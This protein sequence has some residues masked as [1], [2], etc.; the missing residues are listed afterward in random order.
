MRY[1]IYVAAA[2]LSACAAAPAPQS[3]V[4]T[5]DS[6]S[7][8]GARYP[9][10]LAQRATTDASIYLGNLDAKIEVLEGE[11]ARKPTANTGATLAGALLTRFRIV[12]RLDDGERAL[13]LSSAAAL[14]AADQP[15]VHRV[16]ASALSAF[17]LFTDAE[18]ALMQAQAAGASAQSLAAV[19][20]DLQMAQGHYDALHADFEHSA[21]PVA[22]FYEL[23][24]R[25]DLRL[26][27]GD[28]DGATRWYRTAQDFYS[29]VDPLPLAWLYTQQ[30][31]ALL[32]AG[33]TQQAKRFFESAHMRLPQYYLAT[34]HLAECE[35][36]LGNVQHARELYQGVITQTGNPEFLAALALLEEMDGHADAAAS[37]RDQA[38]SSYRALLARHRPA[39][40][41]HAAEFLL[42]I[43]K[44]DEALALARENL[45]IRA[46]YAS[47]SLLARAADAAGAHSESCA[48]V[49]RVR[50]TGLRPPEAAAIVELG[51]QCDRAASAG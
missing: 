1:L 2:L 27:L 22:D 23:A 28:L 50:A 42:S 39:Y 47:L 29:D 40:A 7:V 12:G 19:R 20:R 4:A 34:E 30:G 15:D 36:R 37:A 38:E 43:G 8:F 13:T 9:L 17:H 14:D 6:I 21:E 45:A 18:R 46:D 26:M 3:V 33:D 11:L 25:A 48:A 5:P 10:S 51:S 16:H 31:I 35:A 49:A 44:T 41:Q 24:H 32:R